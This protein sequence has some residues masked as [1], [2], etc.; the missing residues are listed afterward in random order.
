LP[1]K[2]VADGVGFDNKMQQRLFEK[3]EVEVFLLLSL[4]FPGLL[5]S[6]PPGISPPLLI[7]WSP[8][9][10]RAPTWVSHS[11]LGKW[12]GEAGDEI[13]KRFHYL[14]KK[15]SVFWVGEE[16]EGTRNRKKAIARIGE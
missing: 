5:T 15:G 6:V 7:R 10:L 9:G 3:E 11:I 2:L 1:A 16:K 12:R 14:K 8:T 4:R 13:W